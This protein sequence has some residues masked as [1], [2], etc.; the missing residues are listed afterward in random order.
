MA[1]KGKTGLPIR[2]WITEEQPQAILLSNGAQALSPAKLL[3]VI[4]RTGARGI[5]AEE[6]SR[7]LLNELQGLRG[8][9]CASI[10]ELCAF[11]GIGRAKASQLKAA[12]EIGKRL[13]REQARTWERIESPRQAVDYV[14]SYYGPYLRDAKYETLCAIFLDRGN[15]PVRAVELSRGGCGAV[16]VDPHQIVREAITLRASSL[17]VV[18]N[19]PS[20]S[21]EPSHDDMSFTRAVSDACQL[22]EIHLLDHVIIGRNRKDYFS[23]ARA[24]LIRTSRKSS[25]A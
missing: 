22:F 8:I 11:S 7:K 5:S 12:L 19:H 16:T 1:A 24:G 10:E 6:L 21:G 15:C 3:A 25:V 13:C 2:K 4:L 17:I 9:D 14:A 18:H 23:F 20:G